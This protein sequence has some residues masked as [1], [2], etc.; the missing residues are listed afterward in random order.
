ADQLV[1]EALR[2]EV[3]DSRPGIFLEDGVTDG[4]DE[5]RLVKTDAAVDEERVVAVGGTLRDRA[6]G[7]VRELVARADDGVV[8]GVARREPAVLEVENGR[9]WSRG[10]ARHGL[11]RTCVEAARVGNRRGGLGRELRLRRRH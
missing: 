6:R 3:D 1:H 7:G 10:R 2:A 5:M 4:L 9:R 11:L 8:E